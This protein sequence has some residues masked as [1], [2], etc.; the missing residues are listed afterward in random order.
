MSIS[1]SQ[2]PLT[3]C[4]PDVDVVEADSDDKRQTT[5]DKRITTRIAHRK[6]S[7]ASG[8]QQLTNSTAYD[9]SS[10]RDTGIAPV[11]GASA[12]HISV[13]A[14]DLPLIPAAFVVRSAPSRYGVGS[15]VRD[16]WSKSEPGITTD[17]TV[18]VMFTFMLTPEAVLA[19][20]GVSANDAG[21]S[22]P[23]SAISVFQSSVF[24]VYVYDSH[25]YTRSDA[26][27]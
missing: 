1:G 21:D 24:C 9:Q 27:T 13:T 12:G 26:R 16:P 11:L 7:Q 22:R 10:Q 25:T 8:A 6:W 3:W 23:A 4:F 17:V 18:Y 20:D 15:A 2:S 5:D 14:V 19:V